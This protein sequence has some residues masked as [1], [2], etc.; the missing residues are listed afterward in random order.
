M[1]QNPFIMQT[2]LTMPMIM[3]KPKRNLKGFESENKKTPADL[4]KGMIFIF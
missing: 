3:I 4:F 1:K 2:P